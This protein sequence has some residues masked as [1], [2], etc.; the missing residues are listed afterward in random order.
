[1]EIRRSCGSLGHVFQ[2]GEDEV[3]SAARRVADISPEI[4]FQVMRFIP[5]GQAA[6]ELEPSV[7]EAEALCRNLRRYL[8]FV[9][10]FNSPGT[11]ELHLLCPDCGRILAYREFYGPMGARTVACQPEMT[12]SCGSRTPIKG[13][14]GREAYHEDGM[15]GGYR[16][17]R[18][19]EVIRAVC[20]CL[21]LNRD[22]DLIKIWRSVLARDDVLAL[23]D[24]INGLNEYLDLIM[25][26]GRRYGREIRA[27]ALVSHIRHRVD[28]IAAKT[29]KLSRPRVYYAMS[30]PFFALNADRFEIKLANQAGGECVNSR[31]T[32]SGKPGVNISREEL[33]FL[34]PEHIFVSGLFSGSED[35][36]YQ[37]CREKALWIDAVN[38]RR[39]HVVPPG[40]DFGNPRWVLGL[41]YL[42]NILHPECF[43]FDLPAETDLFCRTFY[44]SGPETMIANRS[45]YQYPKAEAS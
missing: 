34:N 31:I 40:W 1:M 14:I 11:T 6:L 13:E 12:C 27:E 4:P 8:D 45:F 44:R 26:L 21:G 32:R 9:Y 33:L 22:E 7:W 3:L 23:H 17:T 28:L 25:E 36:F 16:F 39:I 35:E 37:Q 24:K 20:A 29:G 18:A 42:A 10:L 43:S 15:T 38:Q 30:T 19:L 41:M 5:F 2:G